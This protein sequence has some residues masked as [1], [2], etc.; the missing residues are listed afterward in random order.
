M[1]NAQ[2]VFWRDTM[3]KDQQARAAAERASGE[4][5]RL[6]E[7]TRKS[8]QDPDTGVFARLNELEKAFNAPETGLLAR[9]EV[10]EERERARGEGPQLTGASLM[11]ALDKLTDGVEPGDAIQIAN[12]V[13]TA[14]GISTTVD[15]DLASKVDAHEATIRSKEAAIEDQEKL[16][17]SLRAQAESVQESAKDHLN[18]GRESKERVEG[19]LELIRGFQNI[20]Q[21]A[22]GPAEETDDSSVEPE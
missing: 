1:R 11:A 17:A 18:Q 2:I 16:I 5:V 21:S 9:L 8:L 20:V 3:A 13:A 6:E 10:L 4:V 15:E 22:L 12:F 19:D 7:K 14:L